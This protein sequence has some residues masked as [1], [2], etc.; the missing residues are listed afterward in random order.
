M[1]CIRYTK[2][3]ALLLLAPIGWA[4]SLLPLLLVSPHIEFRFL[5]PS[6]TA[7]AALYLLPFPFILRILLSKV[8]FFP[9]KG[10]AVLIE[11]L[12]FVLIGINAMPSPVRAEQKGRAIRLSWNVDDPAW[13]LRMAACGM[14]YNY[15]LTIEFEHNT[16]TAILRDAVRPIDLSMCPLRVKKSLFTAPRFFCHVQIRP[17]WDL[18]TL[19]QQP[20]EAWR[21]KPQ[22]LKSPV[23]SA[24]IKSGWNVRFTLY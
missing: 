19:E 8:W 6:L 14:R 20:A 18:H 1:L 16:R 5:L 13:C 24:L 11:M 17:D 12:E 23:C 3:C 2:T 4:A 9:G 22:E 15:E 10:E 21:F 7:W